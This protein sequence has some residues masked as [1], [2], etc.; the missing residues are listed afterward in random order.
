MS[1][2]MATALVVVSGPAGTAGASVRSDKS[3]IAQLEQRIAREGELVQTLVSRYDQVEGQLAAIKRQ[4]AADQQALAAGQRAEIAATIRL[5]N[6]AVVAY[7]NASAATQGP[8][9]NTSS[10]TSGQ[11]QQV[12]ESVA[13]G[14]LNSA[15]DAL[16]TDRHSI[17]VAESNLRSEQAR[18][19]A[20]LRQLTTA[21]L[22]AQSAITTDRTILSHV[23]SHLL[24]LVAA[25][26]QRR[27]AA[28]EAAA[29]RKIAQAAAAAEAA[30]PP[31]TTQP[32]VTTTPTTQPP[33][34]TPPSSGGYADPL[35][36]ITGLSPERVDQGVDYSGYGPIYAVGDGVVLATVNG[37]WPGGTFIAYRLTDGPANGLVVY[38]AEDIDPSVQVGQNVTATTVIGQMYEG[39]TG[40]ETGWADGSALGSTMAAQYGQFNG[41]NSTAYGY[42]FSQ[43]L[44]Y[45]GAPG[46]ILQN[47]PPTGSVQS[48]W[49]QW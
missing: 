26:N 33:T 25:A 44:E 16:E 27:E 8:P 41:S 28:Q 22:A 13:G 10:S 20:T 6:V 46:G 38:A 32:P 47:N 35:R 9:I 37:G 36:A 1:S 29:E 11:E 40:I 23:S 17:V 42:N 18:V 34:T 24:A 4:I 43:L 5:R 7:V 45:L 30:K 48:G 21:R 2:A 49:P 39:P 3:K 15:I 14:S 12:Y 19:A 31:P